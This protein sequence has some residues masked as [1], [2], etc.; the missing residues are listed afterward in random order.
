MIQSPPRGFAEALLRCDHLADRAQGRPESQAGDGSDE[1]LQH[2][3][4]EPVVLP[5]GETGREAHRGAVDGACDPSHH[6]VP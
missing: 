1:D 5:P 4:L 6:G 3:V 2:D